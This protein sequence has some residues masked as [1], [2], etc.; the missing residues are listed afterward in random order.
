[1]YIE[2]NST[3]R[4]IHNVPLDPKYEDTLYFSNAIDQAAY[5][6]SLPGQTY[7][8]VTYSR[9][10]KGF[11]RVE[12]PIRSVYDVNYMMFRN[13]DF[14]GHWFYA[15]VTSVEYVSDTVSQI[16]FQLD[17]IQSWFIPSGYLKESF[18]A[19]EMAQRDNIGDNVE[20]ESFALE[21]FVLNEYKQL[22]DL[23]ADLYIIVSITDV[24]QTELAPTNTT[25]ALHDG[26]Y[27]GSTLYA[28][29]SSEIEKV[30]GLITNYVIAGRPDAITG[31]W[32]VPGFCITSTD[33]NG[34]VQ[35]TDHAPR[36]YFSYALGAD[37]NID[38]Y[39]PRNNKLFT[40]PYCFMHV[41]DACGGNLTLKFERGINEEIHFQLTGSVE[42]RNVTLTPCDYMGS[43]TSGAIGGTNHAPNQM[44][45]LAHSDYPLCSWNYDAFQAYLYSSS[46][47]NDFI[48]T[49]S[50]V[51]TSLSKGNIAG[52]INNVIGLV[53]KAN[54]S[55]MQA[56]ITGGSF[57]SGA[58]KTTVNQYHFYGGRMTVTAAKAR[59]IDDFFDLYGYATNRVK[60]PNINGR[61]H[62]NYVQTVGCKIDGNIP[63]D[64]QKQIEDIFDNGIRFW[65]NGSEVRNFELDNRPEE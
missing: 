6:L 23:S 64:Y 16:N 47:Q 7:Q 25:G 60:I 26:I 28:F 9:L 11:T 46:A 41:D 52:A 30:N 51:I 2:P 43:L 40:Y 1:M 36:T 21:D 5:F 19:R 33:E 42:G 32:M 58:A 53:E 35:P 22:D 31:M 48:S 44:L 65:K 17:V 10:Q 45:S 57:S 15:F 27:S 24:T 38:G 61:P 50:H 63:A 37:A 14:E 56:D 12:A 20:P 49:T 13:T 59:I 18:V 34:V 54:T 8:P 29:K 4:L 3:I 55:A 39:S 62:W